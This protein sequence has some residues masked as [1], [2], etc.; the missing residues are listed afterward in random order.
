MRFG[1]STWFHNPYT[2]TKMK[3]T[4]LKSFFSKMPQGN[5]GDVTFTP[6][7]D[8]S[9]FRYVMQVDG[10]WEHDGL[11]GYRKV[12]K[13]GE[14]KMVGMMPTYINGYTK[15]DERNWLKSQGFEV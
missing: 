8:G 11:G 1:P 4:V 10:R 3:I 5:A 2:R 15:Q 7:Y 14:F 12:A 9:C 6:N 13:T